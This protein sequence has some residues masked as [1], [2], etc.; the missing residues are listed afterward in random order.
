MPPSEPRVPLP[1][2]VH[3]LVTYALF[4]TPALAGLVLEKNFHEMHVSRL[5]LFAVIGAWAR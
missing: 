4:A 5:L 3:R 2:A 1:A